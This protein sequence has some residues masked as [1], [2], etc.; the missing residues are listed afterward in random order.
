MIDQSH[1]LKNK[2]EAAL[3]TVDTAQRLML[4]AQLVDRR[5]LATAQKRGDIIAAEH[6]LVDAYETDVRDV[7]AEW[8]MARDLPIDP[9]AE[10][11]AS[12]HQKRAAKQRTAARKARGEVQSSSYA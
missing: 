1:N 3:Q 2:I 7:L 5:R 11:R 9:L 12:G 4:K 6:C 8:R 10:Y